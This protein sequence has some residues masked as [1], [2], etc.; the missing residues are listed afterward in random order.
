M[1]PKASLWCP[2]Q[3]ANC[4]HPETDQPIPQPPITSILI[5]PSH[6]RPAAPE[7]LCPSSFPTKTLYLPLLSPHPCHTPFTH[8]IFQILSRKYYLARDKIMKILIT[9]FL[10]AICYLL[11]LRFKISSRALCSHTLSV[12]VLPLTW[13]TQV[14]HP[15]KITG[16]IIVLYILLFILQDNKLKR[17]DSG[18]SGSSHCSVQFALNFFM[19]ANLIRYICSQRLNSDTFSKSLLSCILFTRHKLLVLFPCTSKTISAFCS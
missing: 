18:T 7:G 8:T 13:R 10:L 19:N 15:H 5:L 6:L 16:T 17:G 1:E 11:L 4:S 14:S 3:P 9:H 2:Q 12:Y